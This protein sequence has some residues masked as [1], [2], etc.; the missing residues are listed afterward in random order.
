M[1][2]VKG[3]ETH[4]TRRIYN[5]KKRRKR[6]SVYFIVIFSLN[7]VLTN[8]SALS[9]QFKDHH[10]ATVRGI[11]R[12][13]LFN[14]LWSKK[15]SHYFCGYGVKLKYNFILILFFFW[16]GKWNCNFSSG[17]TIDWSSKSSKSF[18]YSFNGTD[19]LIHTA[20]LFGGEFYSTVD[21]KVKFMQKF[22]QKKEDDKF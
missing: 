1:V 12:S 22:S 7:F 15:Y 17:S 16:E 10:G 8:F 5:D 18:M 6:E 19:Q 14:C 11:Q 4:T 21:G 20:T 2:K 3:V 13:K 9:F